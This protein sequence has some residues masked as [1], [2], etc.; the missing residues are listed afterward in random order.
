HRS[1]QLTGADLEW[2]DLVL[3]ME[4][5]H[6]RY[7]RRLFPEAAGRTATIRRLCADLA[8]GPGPLGERLDS[9]GLAQVSLHSAEDVADPAGRDEEVYV[10]CAKQL[11]DL[12]VELAE[13]I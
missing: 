2:A 4:G 6:V 8:P 5:D 3:A 10:D 9:L 12:C 13:R 7:V 11:W 1:H